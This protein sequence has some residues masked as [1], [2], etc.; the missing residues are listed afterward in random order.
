MNVYVIRSPERLTTF[1]RECRKFLLDSILHHYSKLKLRYVAVGGV[2]NELSNRPKPPSISRRR[3]EEEKQD[4]KGKQK[5]VASDPSTDADDSADYS[6]I[7]TKPADG[8][9]LRHLKFWETHGVDI[10]RTTVRTG[11]L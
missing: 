7:E 10:F 8:P 9:V 3:T 5:A 11:K 1:I 6:D 4:R 2:V